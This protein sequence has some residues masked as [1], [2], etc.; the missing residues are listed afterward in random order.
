MKFLKQ[1]YLKR[2][3]KL[4]FFSFIVS[5][6]WGTKMFAQ[7]TTAP[8]ASSSTWTCPPGVTAISVEA[9]GG[10]GGGAG[11]ASAT[12]RAGSGGSGGN[13]V[14]NTA[15]AVTPGLTYTITVGAGGPGGIGS[16]AALSDG[17]FSAVTNPS[18]VV[19]LRAGGGKKGVFVSGN[20]VQ[21]LGGISLISDNSG[22]ESP[23]NYKGGNGGNSTNGN[24][25]GPVLSIEAAG[26]GAAG[27]NGNG[28][29]ISAG[30]GGGAGGSLATGNGVV[31]TAPGG[32]GSG[33]LTAASA[34]ARTG[35]AGGLGRVV[36]SYATPVAPSMTISTATLSGFLTTLNVASASQSFT[37]SG[38]LLTNDIVVN[39]IAG[40]NFEISTN[41]ASFSNSITLTAPGNGTIGNTTIYVRLK[42]VSLNANVNEAITASSTGALSSSITSTGIV[43]KNFFYNS[44]NLQDVSSWT[45]NQNGTGANP[46][47]FTSAAQAFYILKDATSSGIGWIVGNGNGVVA[48]QGLTNGNGTKI[49][50]G[51]SSTN[52]VTLTIANGAPVT[53]PLDISAAA[54]AGSNKLVISHSIVWS[55]STST[56]TSPTWGSVDPSATIEVSGASSNVVIGGSNNLFNKT[57]KN[58]RVVN[59]GVLRINSVTGNNFTT[60][61]QLF[62][63]EGATFYPGSNSTNYANIASGGAAVINGTLVTEKQAGFTSNDAVASATSANLNFAGTVDLTLGVNSVIDF[64]RSTATTI[65]QIITSRTD[66]KNINLSGGNFKKDFLGNITV[67]GDINVTALNTTNNISATGGT[68][69]ANAI[70]FNGLSAFLVAQPQTISGTTTS[71]LMN[72]VAPVVIKGT[73]TLGSADIIANSSKLILSGG[74]FGTGAT[75]GFNETMGALGLTENSVVALGTAAHSVTFAASNAQSWTVGKTL[76]IT[77]WTGTSG[78]SGTSG[79][80]FVGSNASALTTQ[81][82]SQISFTGFS[83]SIVLL[84]SGELVPACTNPTSGGT[85]TGTQSICEN[86]NPSNFLSTAAANGFEGILEYKW[87]SSDDNAIFT[88]VSGAIFSTYN[89]PAGSTATTF[90]KRLARVDCKS[91]WTGAAESNVITVTVNPILTASVS[92]SA[93]ATT[94]CAG[95]SV[96]FTASAVNGGTPVYQWKINGTNAGSNSATFTSSSLADDDLVTVVMTST[97]SPCLAN[98]T[99]TSNAIYVTVNAVSVAG[100]ATGTTSMC[101]GNTTDISVSGSTGVV[102]W[103]YSSNGSTNWIAIMG[104]TSATI[105]TGASAA[106]TYYRAVVTSGVCGSATSNTVVVT[107]NITPAPTTSAQTVPLTST[108]ASL[109]ATGSG[110]RW[111]LTATG[112]SSLTSNTTLVSGT[113]YYASQTLN[114]CEGESRAAALVTLFGIPTT[115]I[116]NSQ[117]GIT[118]LSINTQIAANVVTGAQLYRFEVTNGATVN[119]VDVNKYNFKLTQ[120]PG[121]TYGTT[122]GVRVAVRMGGIWGAYGVSCTITTPSIISASS[123]PLTKIR[124]SDCGTTLPVLSREIHANLITAAT[125]YRFEITNGASVTTFVSPIYYFNLTNIAGAAYATTYSIK[126]AAQVAGTWGN[127]GDAC[128][129]TTPVLSV[130][131]IPTT[132]IK[133]SFCGTT[134]ATLSSKIPALL[135]YNAEGYRFEI[136]RA[137]VVTVYDSG[138]YNFM[139]SEAVVVVTNGT[140]YTIRVAAKINGVYGNYGVSCNVTTPGTAPTSRQIEAPV[141]KQADFNLVAFPNPF[142]NAF[143]LQINGVG[144]D[145]VS[146]LVFDMTGR[147]IESKNVAADAIENVTLGQN[148]SSGVYNVIVSQGMNT[149]SVRLVKK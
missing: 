19:L 43:Y 55:T 71:F 44:G 54:S 83:T 85:I 51:G 90:Y 141:V 24:A 133:Q 8:F 76:T 65:P 114:G 103:Q 45:L 116:R 139:L 96:T 66:Y 74:T 99:V 147:Q 1:L 29:G 143:K 33:G 134:L 113:T 52:A 3:N 18:S 91:D 26:G 40:S 15:I 30:T 63:E 41:N 140:T 126:V 119:T 131:I 120:T 16:A 23:F 28:S 95:T 36:I 138:E 59:N 135:V 108:V 31:G 69:T 129:I 13:Y 57:I 72:T 110:I 70:V 50:L 84:S 146:I 32:G 9:W 145:K 137:G 82:L 107:V 37:I 87:Q 117:C 81:Q 128:L 5:V 122:Y 25:T 38:A 53:G 10:G 14:K 121:I 142:D 4:L 124:P 86:G 118:I 22:S 62:I 27:S 21:N 123:V 60:T 48:G 46:A 61:G 47:D 67:S 11:T 6:L 39:T 2:L 98:A 115:K 105:N 78:Q 88:D 102:Q 112:G 111:Y 101:P 149:Q 77:G 42:S 97:V 80:I 20:G 94:I 127:Y 34:V 109:N 68:I 132:Q 136:T 17:G 130:G 104:T 58:V 92:I 12:Y 75:T 7:T 106:T 64:S 89:P 49:I 56:W 144:K 100:I 148:Y 79:K 73:A 35:G 93:T 125:A